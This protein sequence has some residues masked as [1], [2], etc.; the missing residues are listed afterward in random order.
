MAEIFMHMLCEA[1]KR[2]MPCG[3]RIEGFSQRLVPVRDRLEENLRDILA[4]E[5]PHESI[6]LG[7]D[8]RPSQSGNLSRHDDCCQEPVQPILL[9]QVHLTGE[10]VI[11][12]I[13]QGL[14]AKIIRIKRNRLRHSCGQQEEQYR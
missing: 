14:L 11:S 3:L 13:I 2:D 10:L 5:Y 8:D 7:N 9:F 4:M 12:L 1:I 6:P